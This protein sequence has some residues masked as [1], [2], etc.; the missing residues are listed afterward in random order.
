MTRQKVW[1]CACVSE[2]VFELRRTNLYG[3]YPKIGEFKR[4][5]F[6]FFGQRHA[7]STSFDI[8]VVTFRV[9]NFLPKLVDMLLFS[10]ETTEFPFFDFSII[11]YCHLYVHVHL[12]CRLHE[13]GGEHRRQPDSGTEL[14]FRGRDT[15]LRR[16][17]SL[18]QTR[19]HLTGNCLVI[20]PWVK[21]DLIS[22]VTAW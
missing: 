16:N 17:S 8:F 1:N 14:Q 2:T 13:R 6:S 15:E 11:G 10:A 7:L 18:G 12:H 20:A 4:K 9:T 21:P 3:Q 19:P 22:Q 5:K